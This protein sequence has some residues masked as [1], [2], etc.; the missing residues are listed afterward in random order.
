MRLTVTNKSKRKENPGKELIRL[1]NSMIV[2]GITGDSIF[3]GIRADLERGLID[4]AR[5]HLNFVDV[6]VKPNMKAEAP[7]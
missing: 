1:R 5:M 3:S 6:M 4:A 2:L 7:K